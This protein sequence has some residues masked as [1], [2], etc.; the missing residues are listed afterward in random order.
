[1][2][3]IM[4]GTRTVT[5]SVP[6]RSPRL[7]VAFGLTLQAIGVGSVTAY[8]WFKLR[9]EGIGGHI[10]AATI[11]L[12]WHSDLHTRTG[13]AVLMAGAL[14][15]V[16]G[17]ILVAR[18]YVSRPVTLFVA[19]PVAA[20]AGM[21]VLGVLVLIVA[22]VITVL[23]DFPLPFDFGGGSSRRRRPRGHDGE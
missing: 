19:V 16:A 21:L 14:I 4:S 20:V 8:G 15:Y 22:V 6:L 12:A 7:W 17:S 13:P 9:R 10:T 23:D 5:A 2:C 11:R 1:M 18:P 3:Y